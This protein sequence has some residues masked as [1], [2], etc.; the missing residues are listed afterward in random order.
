MA[1]CLGSSNHGG[2]V[3]AQAQL[4]ITNTFTLSSHCGNNRSQESTWHHQH[5]YAEFTLWKQE[6][7]G[8]KPLIWGWVMAHAGCS[9]LVTILINDGASHCFI[10]SSVAREWGLEQSGEPGPA[11][12]LLAAGDVVHAVDTPVRV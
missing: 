9:I 11:G 8:V 3:G 6:E 5:I 2:P 12:V 1:D 7:P 10:N 4:G